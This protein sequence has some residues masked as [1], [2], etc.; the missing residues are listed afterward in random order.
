MRRPRLPSTGPS[1]SWLTNEHGDVAELTPDEQSELALKIRYGIGMAKLNAIA[2]SAPR[3]PARP[4][5]IEPPRNPPA[6]P[7]RSPSS[8]SDIRSRASALGVGAGRRGQW[9][10]R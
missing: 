2:D 7:D 9:L 8:D 4:R 5:R 3:V 1:R 10:R 6:I